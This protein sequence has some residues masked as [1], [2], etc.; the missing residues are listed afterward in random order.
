M[1]TKGMYNR[2]DNREGCGCICLF[3]LREF[4]EKLRKID[5]NIQQLVWLAEQTQAEK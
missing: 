4:A 5:T 3:V 2:P 1:K